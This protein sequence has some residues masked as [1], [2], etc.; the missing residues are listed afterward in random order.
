[1]PPL[2]PRTAHP[3]VAQMPATCIDALC[4]AV[5]MVGRIEP[6]SPRFVTMLALAR[7]ARRHACSET[8]GGTGMRTH[9]RRPQGSVV[10]VCLLAL[11]IGPGR[12]PAA[13]DPSPPVY[14]IAVEHA[15]ISMPDGVRLS[16]DLYVP[17]GAAPGERF[18]VLLEYLPY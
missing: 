14:G 4:P 5:R 12:V 2:P 6:A 17:E 15:W 18:P 7:A 8:T 3:H 9:A 11:V 1:T 10:I 13:Q 16:A